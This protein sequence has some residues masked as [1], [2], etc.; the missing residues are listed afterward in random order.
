MSLETQVEACLAAAE[1]R[2]YDVSP[3]LI[4]KEIH[5]GADLWDRPMLSRI[6]DLV[7]WGKIDAVF[8][9][10]IDRLTREPTHL[11]ILIEEFDRYQV[12][13]ELIQEPV[14]KSPEGL[15]IQYVRGYAARVEREK[16]KERTL[17]GK[18]AKLERGE[19]IGTRPLYGYRFE[20]GRRVIV[21]EE[22]RV[23]RMIF[24]WAADGVPIREIARRLTAQG[25]R[26]PRGNT[27]WSKSTISRILRNEAYVGLTYA[28]KWK[29]EGKT[30]RERPREEWIRLPVGVT[31]PIIDESTWKETQVR[32]QRNKELARRRTKHTEDYLLRGYVFCG[33]CGKRMWAERRKRGQGWELAYRCRGKSGHPDSTC[34]RGTGLPYINARELDS[35]VWSH[36]ESILTDPQ[37]IAQ[38]LTRLEDEA[39]LERELKD[40]DS[41]IRKVKREKGNLLAAIGDTDDPEVRGL[42][43]EELRKKAAFLR[44]LERERATLLAQRK[45]RKEAKEQLK[46][47][48]EWCNIVAQ[49]LGSLSFEER[50]LALEALQ[51]RVWVY[52]SGHDPRVEL[53]V[54]VPVEGY[55]SQS[56]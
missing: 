32:L 28:W 44:D 47:V 19:L 16:I 12:T 52:R 6:R 4:F 2:G 18:R 3:D 25:I 21:P 39:N 5:S 56:S 43:L 24:G 13:L 53:E 41:L 54:N 49:R 31:P 50:R 51:V 9:Y 37:V 27:R 1:A 38:E 8:C 40:L 36:I 17:R 45:G 26:S 34:E 42:I 55:Q 15:L 35:Y 14:D 22:A 48:L 23:V 7:R 46:S 10:S 11:V 30:V 33:H 29:R 20:E